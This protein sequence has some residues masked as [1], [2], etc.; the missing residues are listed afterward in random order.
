MSTRTWLAVLLVLG[1]TGWW[2]SPLSPRVPPVPARADPDGTRICRMPP[3]VPRGSPPLQTELPA[4]IVPFRLEGALVEPLAG[5]SVEARVLGR[6][7]YHFGPEAGFSPTDLALGWGR[8][9]DAAVLDRLDIGQ[10]GRWYHYR[11]RGD[12]PL[13]L[14]EIVRS[15]AN[16]HMVPADER[17]AASLHRVKPDDR[18]RIDGWLVRIDADDGWH[19]TSSLRRD[20]SGGGACELVYVCDITIE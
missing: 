3:R 7:D 16:M 8:M 2:H 10:S 20:D 9:R 4:G 12:P 18:V 5:F 1:L 14:A 17:V 6:E 19:W 13:A 11:W 15:S